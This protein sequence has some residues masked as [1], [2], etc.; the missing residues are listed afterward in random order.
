MARQFW[1]NGRAVGRL[2]HSGEFSSEPYEVVGVSRDHKVRSMGEAPRAYMHVP[3]WPSTSIGLVVRTAVPSAAALPMLR[4]AVLDLEPDILFTEDVPAAEVVA[5]TMMPTRIGAVAV[6]AFGSLALLLAAVGLYGVVT[7]S[8][9][10][11]TREIGIRLA[12]GAQRGQ[13]IRMILLQG[14]RLA[15]GGIAVGALGAAAT[16]RVLESLLYGVS[17]FDPIAYGAAGSLLLLVSLLANLRP[18][19]MA[20]SVDPV[21][22]LQNE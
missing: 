14:G 8:V 15:L 5:T 2:L 16:G 4:K 12:V 13:V 18:A 7:Q 11:R 19:L 9:S 6:G 10:R 20:S 22:A 3:S 21:R 1:A 17:T